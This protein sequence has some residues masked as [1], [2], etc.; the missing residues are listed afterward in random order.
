MKIKSKKERKEKN[1]WGL[2]VSNKG[3]IKWKWAY[4]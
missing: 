3:D 4:A 2:G 1:I